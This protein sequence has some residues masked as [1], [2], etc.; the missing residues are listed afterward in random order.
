M[1]IFAE[2]LMRLRRQ[3]GFSQEQLGER[4]NVSRQ[5]VSKWESGQTTPEMD[6]LIALADLFD[7]SIDELAGRPARQPPDPEQGAKAGVQYEP[8]PAYMASTRWWYQTV[9]EYKSERKVLGLPLVHIHLGHGNCRARGI[10]AIGNSAIG[11]VAV[12]F[13]SIG[14]VSVGLTAV[15]LLA[16]GLVCAGGISFGGVVLGL[17]AA[18]GGVAVSAGLTVGGIATGT[19]AFGKVASGYFSVG[20]TAAGHFAVGPNVDG[21]LVFRTVP[22][23]L[24]AIGDQLPG[25]LQWLLRTFH[26]DGLVGIH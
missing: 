16:L 5:T 22:E 21:T 26:F 1:R 6:K 11:L 12:G 7:V 18:F 20:T 17:I 13:A 25:W 8:V 23:A 14:V 4:V 2:N 9:Y 19:Y 24:E 3:H 10:L 15:G